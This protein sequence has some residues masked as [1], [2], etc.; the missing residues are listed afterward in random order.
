MKEQHALC[1]YSKHFSVLLIHETLNAMKKIKILVE[2]YFW[3]YSSNYGSNDAFIGD[4]R[5]YEND[6]VSHI[7]TAEYCDFKN[8]VGDDDE[9]HFLIATGQFGEDMEKI[10]SVYFD[11]SWDCNIY[12]SKWN[13][14]RDKKRTSKMADFVQFLQN[15]K[16]ENMKYHAKNKVLDPLFFCA[17]CFAAVNNKI[18]SLSHIGDYII[19]YKTYHDEFKF[20]IFQEF[21]PVFYSPKSRLLLQYLF[22]K[23]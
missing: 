6:I 4:I 21:L 20:E 12:N 14:Y 17:S 16:L 15:I 9:L 5:K 10:L 8:V 13:S 11:S 2:C 22:M 18:E 7:L 3:C 1:F 19:K 23:K